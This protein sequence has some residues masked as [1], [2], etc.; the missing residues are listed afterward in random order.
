MGFAS[1]VTANLSIVIRSFFEFAHL[2]FSVKKSELREKRYSATVVNDA[3]TMP[4]ECL[5][6]DMGMLR[7]LIKPRVKKLRQ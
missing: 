5:A 2:M 1:V 4:G 6:C 7:L 3:K